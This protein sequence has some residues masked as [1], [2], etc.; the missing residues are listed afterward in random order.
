MREAGV[1]FRVEVAGVDENAE[2]ECPR[3][4]AAGN[5]RLKGEAVASRFPGEIVLA[6]DTVVFVAGEILGKPADF[7][8]ARRMLGL[9]CGKTHEVVTAVWIGTADGVRSAFAETTRVTFRP[10]AEVDI[11]AYL[12]DIGPLDK[13]GAYA[14]QEDGGR[15]IAGYEG[16]F[17]N[18]VGLPVE[19]VVPELERL[20]FP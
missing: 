14:A 5:A 3:E 15:I 4:S 20:F 8:E 17:S 9:L 16:L 2:G 1:D 7:A 13:A 10:E 18:V 6:A 19:R 11:P 12:A